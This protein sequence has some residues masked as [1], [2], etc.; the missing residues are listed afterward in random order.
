MLA[1]YYC[2]LRYILVQCLNEDNT[3]NPYY[4]YRCICNIWVHMTSYYRTMGPYT[5]SDLDNV[6]NDRCICNIWVHMTR[7]YYTVWRNMHDYIEK[8]IDTP[9]ERTIQ[10]S[11]K[12]FYIE[13][14]KNTNT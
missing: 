2:G 11:Q 13:K 8:N 6:Y 14:Y 7:V 12:G 10:I 9:D 3:P 5:F 1:H 4:P